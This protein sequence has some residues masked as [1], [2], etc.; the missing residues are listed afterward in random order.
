MSGLSTSAWFTGD[1][2]PESH[3]PRIDGA[4]LTIGE[5]FGGSETPPAESR[6]CGQTHTTAPTRT[7]PVTPA[8]RA[9]VSMLRAWRAWTPDMADRGPVHNMLVM[10]GTAAV[11]AGLVDAETDDLTPAGRDLLA[12]VDASSPTGRT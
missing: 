9:A 6:E 2:G 3:R 10:F 12:R 1:D 4:D 5:R 7:L 11:A 8:E